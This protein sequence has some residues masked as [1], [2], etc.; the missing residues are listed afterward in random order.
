MIQETWLYGPRPRPFQLRYP[1]HK[2]SFSGAIT[3]LLT[4]ANNFLEVSLKFAGT[5]RDFT[6]SSNLYLYICLFAIMIHS[7]VGSS[8]TG[9]AV[10]DS[11]GTSTTVKGNVRW[12][13]LKTLALVTV[14]SKT[15]P[16]RSGK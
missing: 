5:A 10:I 9:L 6:K 8:D 2:Y 3:V 7:K 11:A 15:C 12:N 1:Y 16:A 4:T 13:H 14:C